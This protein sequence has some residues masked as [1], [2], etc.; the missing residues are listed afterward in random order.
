M[1]AI[2][3]S[4]LQITT[5]IMNCTAPPA[6]PAPRCALSLV[7][8][9]SIAKCALGSTFG[10]DADNTTMWTAGG[11]RGQFLCNG[12]N[13]TCDVDGAGQHECPCG[14]APS[15][16][17]TCK[18]WL[19]DLQKDIML[20]KEVIAINQDV[21]PQG[22]PIKDGDISVWARALSDGS[23]AVALYN[24]ND[25]PLGASVS[26]KDL[27]AVGWGAGTVAAVRDLWAH[28]DLPAA[29]GRY[30]AQGAVTLAPHQTVLLRLT[31]Q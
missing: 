23:V 16:P 7:K 14:G 3:A 20:N 11:C 2:S 30:P 21:T 5:A 12:A 26:F 27:P 19:S 13:V 1:W 9:T 29:T 4:P 18:G 25:A 15:G 10:C 31:K 6:P 28:A 22:R 24:E 8:Q 17:V